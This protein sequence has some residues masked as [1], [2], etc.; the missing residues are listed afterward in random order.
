[1]SY[2]PWEA[3]LSGA[4]GFILCCR[5]GTEVGLCDDLGLVDRK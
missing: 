3:D 1:M 2:L 4:L 5:G